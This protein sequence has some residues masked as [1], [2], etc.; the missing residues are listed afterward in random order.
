[1]SL[2]A[3]ISDDYNKAYKSGDKTTVSILRII[4]STIKN[5]EIEKGEGLDD[6]EI[7]AII[8]SFE[9]RAKESIEQFSKADRSDLVDKEKAELAI[10]QSYLPK[11]LSKDEVIE[12]VKS[13]I[14]ETG[15]EGPRDMGK[16][17]KAVMAKSRG[18][19]DGNLA[20]KVVKT[21][22]EA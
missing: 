10:V 21:M 1:M 3:R 6:E 14:S 9:K 22:L 12:I 17:M 8:R 7:S 19:V 18:Q 15:A 4:K 5:R 20:N 2:S 11:Q 16:V 13:A